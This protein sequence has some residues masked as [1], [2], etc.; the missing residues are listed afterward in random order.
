MA[1]RFIAIFLIFQVGSLLY[2]QTYLF[3]DDIFSGLGKSPEKYKD[4]KEYTYTEIIPDKNRLGIQQQI[5]VI[6]EEIEIYYFKIDNVFRIDLVKILK[7]TDKHKFGKYIGISKDNIALI[8]GEP[9]N[10]NEYA[11][12]YYSK[13]F[14]YYVTFTF[15]DDSVTK[16]TFGCS[17]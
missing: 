3:E 9:F 11:Y 12:F 1:I 13:D 4:D 5:N 10:I 8:F 2:A 7:M 15:I 14:E 6:N 17:R 16:I